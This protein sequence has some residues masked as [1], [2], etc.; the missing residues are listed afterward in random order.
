MPEQSLV[1]MDIRPASTEIQPC[2]HGIM[3]WPKQDQV[4]GKALMD[5]GEF[6][7]GEN[8]VMSRYLRAGDVA[9]DVGANVG[10][11]ALAMAQQVGGARAARI[12]ATRRN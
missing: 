9:V 10:T 1:F 11:T 3:F 4:I 2:R 6:A 8:I 5:Y 12:T 7:E